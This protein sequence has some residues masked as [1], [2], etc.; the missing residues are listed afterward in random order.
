MGKYR[1]TGPD[2]ATYDVEAPD[3]ASEQDILSYVQ[4]SARAPAAQPAPA[5]PQGSI[6]RQF[7]QELEN[8]MG[9]GATLG[10]S[11]AQMGDIV[12]KQLG[13]RF[14]RMESAPSQSQRPQ[15]RAG[16]GQEI[17]DVYKRQA[18]S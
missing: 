13:D 7:P 12:K 4:K 10:A 6:Y 8:P 17:K 18:Q 16:Q 9:M 5:A 3:G 15:N 11:D 14:I 2:G 1:I